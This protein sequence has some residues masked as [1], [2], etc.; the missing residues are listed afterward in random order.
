M[1]KVVAEVLADELLAELLE[2]LG[3]E[4]PDT[5]ELLEV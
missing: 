1:K 5:L 3:D 2:L 4:L